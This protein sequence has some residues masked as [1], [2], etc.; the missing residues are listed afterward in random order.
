M[1]ILQ[2]NQIDQKTNK[3]K[4]AGEGGRCSLKTKESKA[5]PP[6]S[7]LHRLPEN[8]LKLELQGAPFTQRA[9]IQEPDSATLRK[10]CR[11]ISNNGTP[12][13]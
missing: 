11:E 2:N 1:L 12:E 9:Q 10:G 6:G 4:P 7:L 13:G 8:S 5:C 3:K